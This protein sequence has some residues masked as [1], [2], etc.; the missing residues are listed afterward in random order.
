MKRRAWMS[1][2]VSK[3]GCRAGKLLVRLPVSWYVFLYRISAS[4][5][6]TPLSNS[7]QDKRRY[8]LNK[9][10]SAFPEAEFMYNHV[11]ISGHTHESSF[12]DLRVLYIYL[13]TQGRGHGFLSGFHSFSFTETVRSCGS[14]KKQISQVKL[15]R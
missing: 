11:E 3:K 5:D 2:S 12:S 13:K 1:L 10:V 4:S 7:D 9:S 8:I 15:Q 14:F 6:S